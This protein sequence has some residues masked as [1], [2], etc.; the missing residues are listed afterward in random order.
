MGQDMDQGLIKKLL[1]NGLKSSLD[2][3]FHPSLRPPP[4]LVSFLCDLTV[5][6]G[7]N[8]ISPV[9]PDGGGEDD[10]TPDKHRPET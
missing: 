3:R 1:G 4:H 5:T 6:T 10:G 9:S 2:N 8:H 7:A